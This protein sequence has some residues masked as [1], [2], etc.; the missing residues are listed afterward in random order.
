M[1]A[2]LLDQITTRSLR[3][4]NLAWPAS[5]STWTQAANLPTGGRARRQCAS[6][7]SCCVRT[8]F[9]GGSLPPLVKLLA[10]TEWAHWTVCLRESSQIRIHRLP[11]EAV[12]LIAVYPRRRL[13][14]SWNDQTHAEWTVLWDRE[15]HV[16]CLAS[17]EHCCDESSPLRFDPLFRPE[18]LLDDRVVGVLLVNHVGPAGSIG[19]V[20]YRCCSDVRGKDSS[21]DAVKVGVLHREPKRHHG[22][23]CRTGEVVA[24]P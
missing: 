22:V 6:R 15:R 24:A 19:S 16:G 14:L 23:A 11:V 3:V 13:R 1:S 8:P 10:R 4:S 2:A 12:I 21:V 17:V 20:H 5:R 9:P 18:R 7:T